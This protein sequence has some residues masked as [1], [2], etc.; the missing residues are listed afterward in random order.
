VIT[1]AII[2]VVLVLAAIAIGDVIN[3]RGAGTSTREESDEAQLK[4][5]RE[6]NEQHGNDAA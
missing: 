2:I 5:L 1:A 3:V 4:F 6:W